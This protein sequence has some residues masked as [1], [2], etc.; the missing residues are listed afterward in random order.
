MNTLEKIRETNR[1]EGIDRAPT[2]EELE[3]FETF[4]QLEQIE[5]YD[6]E[7]FVRIYQPGAQLRIS[8]GHNVTV[9]S[10]MPP[11]G[12]Q[13]IL[14]KLQAILEKCNDINSHHN[15]FDLHIEYEQLHPFTDGNGRSGRM[16]WYWMMY[17][18]GN[19]GFLH[20]FYYQTLEDKQPEIEV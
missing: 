20:E 1:I 3:Q 15:A 10:Y 19:L 11:T 2:K 8:S 12:G 17:P 13:K 9:G 5:I 16:L 7:N 4:M 6:L 18:R 14:Y